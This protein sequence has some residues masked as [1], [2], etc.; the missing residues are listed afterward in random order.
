MLKLR[1]EGS[2]WEDP[3]FSSDAFSI[4]FIPSSWGGAACSET[5]TASAFGANVSA[6]ADGGALVV[7]A[8]SGPRTLSR[9][10]GQAAS[11]LFQFDVA[12]TPAKPLNLTA[13]F[14]QRYLQVGYGAEQQYV[15]PQQA[16][17]RNVSVVTLHQGIA[18]V[19]NGTLVNPYMW[20]E[21]Y[22]RTCVLAWST[23]PLHACVLA[24][25]L[26]ACL[27]ADWLFYS[28]RTSFCTCALQ[29]TTRSCRRLWT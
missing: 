3:L 28:F 2:R 11:Q 22:L 26:R 24:Y 27:P 5:C 9:A 13:H 16:A 21:A 12:A 7:T 29:A 14:E 15:S 17:R 8:F 25:C 20:V 6:S 23:A 1:G 10:A 19:V 18:G 4:P